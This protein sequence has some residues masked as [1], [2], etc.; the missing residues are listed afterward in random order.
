MAYFITRI[1]LHGALTYADYQRLHAAM[2]S[3]GF[4]RTVDVG[5]TKRSLPTAEYFHGDSV[6]TQTIMNKAQAA[7]ATAGKSA[8]I[9]VSHV[10]DGLA[11]GL[12][13][14]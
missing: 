4:S 9:L 12:S 3:S 1:E 14:A 13:A 10:S 2:Q 8:A 6:A 5:G 11:E 7:V